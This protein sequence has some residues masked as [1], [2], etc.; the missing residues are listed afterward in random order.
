MLSCAEAGTK[1]QPGERFST[2]G[3]I[4]VQFLIS[5]GDS[6]DDMLICVPQND[7]VG[8]SG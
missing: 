4:I 6:E 1:R 7:E 5:K 3:R 2:D 8:E